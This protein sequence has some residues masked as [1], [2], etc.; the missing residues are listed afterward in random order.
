MK[1]Y[2]D[3]NDVLTIYNEL[4]FTLTDKLFPYDTEWLNA[5]V[6]GRVKFLVDKC[7]QLELEVTRGC[8][9]PSDMRRG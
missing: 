4:E 8:K 5:D 2:L 9:L 7:N 1:H 3:I 6:V